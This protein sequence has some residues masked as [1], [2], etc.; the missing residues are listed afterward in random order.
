VLFGL[1]K[2]DAIHEKAPLVRGFF[3]SDRQARISA[4]AS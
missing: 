1:K 2:T 4:P 3:V